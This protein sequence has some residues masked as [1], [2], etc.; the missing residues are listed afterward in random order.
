M[1]ELLFLHGVRL[2]MIQIRPSDLYYKYPRDTNHRGEPKFS[3]KPDR[4][5][6]NRNDLYEVLPMFS[7][8]MDGLD[9]DDERT[10]H[11]IEELMI[12]EMPG[13]ISTR[14]EVFLAVSFV[15]IRR[16]SSP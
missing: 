14:E 8:V 11:Q 7:A 16:E 4:H 12:H 6:F 15:V 5:P 13:F 2:Q 10:L 1:Q 9:R 3:G